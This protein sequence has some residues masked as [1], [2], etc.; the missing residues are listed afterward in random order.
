MPCSA[1]TKAIRK[2][3]NEKEQEGPEQPEKEKR[4]Y[5]EKRLYC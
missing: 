5:H 2:V 1:Q 4:R 3:L